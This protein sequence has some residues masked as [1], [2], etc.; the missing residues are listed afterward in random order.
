MNYLPEI[1][2]TVGLG[3]SAAAVFERYGT[4]NCCMYVGG[5]LLVTSILMTFKRGQ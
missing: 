4:A 3:M 2:Y 1:F 5:V